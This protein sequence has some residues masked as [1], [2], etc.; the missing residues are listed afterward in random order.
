MDFQCTLI[1]SLIFPGL[2]QNRF[3]KNSGQYNRECSDF[4]T[5]IQT[6]LNWTME[7]DKE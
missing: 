3:S 6:T 2:Q 4:N 1:L 7:A 5:S